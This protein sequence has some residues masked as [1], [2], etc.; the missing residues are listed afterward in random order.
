MQYAAVVLEMHTWGP[1]DPIGAKGLADATACRL[2]LRCMQPTLAPAHSFFRPLHG[3]DEWPLWG[4][5]L[6]MHRFPYYLV[7]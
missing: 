7:G 4:T 1:H 5:Y 6:R 2:S 3:D